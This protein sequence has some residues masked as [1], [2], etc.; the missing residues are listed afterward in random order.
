MY[1]AEVARSTTWRTRLDISTNWAIT[2]AAAVLSVAFSSA[3]TPHAT[4]LVGL[5][6][7]GTFLVIESRRYRYYD[8][9]ARR[10]RLLESAYLVPLL[11]REQATDD[12]NAALASELARPRLHI[13]M[14]DSVC[15]RLTRTYWPLIALMLLGWVVKLDVHPTPATRVWQLVDRAEIGPLP[16]ELA[17][18][19]WLAA[20]GVTIWM[21]WRSRQSSLPSTELRAAKPRRREL[22]AAVQRL[23]ERGSRPRAH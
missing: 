4:L 10:V 18:I 16:G 3:S 12:F 11:R 23:V 7:L 2:S 15:F 22:G 9:W 8:M 13:S 1:R 20:T 21:V 17:W 6:L 14:L 19:A 5:I